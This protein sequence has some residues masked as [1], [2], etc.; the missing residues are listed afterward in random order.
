MNELNFNLEERYTPYQEIILRGLFGALAAMIVFFGILPMGLKSLKTGYFAYDGFVFYNLAAQFCMGAITV[1]CLRG[2][3]PVLKILELDKWDWGHLKIGVACGILIL[4]I[5]SIIVYVNIGIYRIFGIDLSGETYV[6]FMLRQLSW[7]GFAVFALTAI[8]IAPVTEEIIF[9]RVIFSFLAS[10]S[11]RIGSVLLCSLIFALIHV[12][13]K[14]LPA[15]FVLGIVFQFLMIWR[16]SLYPA[17]IMHMTNNL[18]AILMSLTMR[19]FDI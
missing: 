11:S 9:R 13:L 6:E 17:I 10:K 8:V 5:N 4:P 19:C 7:P 16:K 18:A 12:N 2:S 15:L 3:I 1:L 14:N